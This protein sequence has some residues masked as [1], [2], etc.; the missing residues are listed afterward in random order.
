MRTAD[1]QATGV[2]G[3]DLS[4]GVNLG[5]SFTNV[6]G[7]TAHCSFTGGTNY[8]D[9]SGDVAIVINKANA[10]ITVTGYDVKYD[11][12]AH[13]ATGSAT[14]GLGESLSGLDLTGT[15]HINAG[16]YSGTWKF[17]DATGN[18][19]DVAA[20]P[21]TDKITY[22]NSGAFLDPINNPGH[23]D[24]ISQFKFG[25]TV[26]VKFWIKAADG[27]PVT[28]TDASLAAGGQPK[29]T[30]SYSQTNPTADT[31]TQLESTVTITPDSGGNFRY[32]STGQQWIY[33]F[34]TKSLPT[35]LGWYTLNAALGDGTS[36]SVVI[37]LV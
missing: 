10:T 28:S 34:G 3:A 22:L 32:D 36:L 14:G 7:G 25:S 13:T 21:I 1:I 24:P 17:T 16:I 18:Y 11:R 5:A 35:K 33:N 27:T 2:G 29:F 4:S 19:N 31:A 23:G 30:Y 37:Q 9:K 12:T 26:P 15:T 6:P 20:T 8:N